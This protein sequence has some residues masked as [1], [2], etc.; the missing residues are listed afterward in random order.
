MTISFKFLSFKLA[1]YNI[2]LYNYISPHLESAAEVALYGV[3]LRWVGLHNC[4]GLHP[5]LFLKQ[6]MQVSGWGCSVGDG[7]TRMH[8]LYMQEEGNYIYIIL[9]SSLSLSLC[10]VSLLPPPSIHTLADLAP[11]PLRCLTR[12]WLSYSPT[13]ITPSWPPLGRTHGWNWGR[14][15]QHLHVLWS[16]GTLFGIIRVGLV[17]HCHHSCGFSAFVK[18]QSRLIYILRRVCIQVKLI[19]ANPTSIPSITGNSNKQLTKLLNTANQWILL[20]NSHHCN[21]A[22]V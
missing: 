1:L 2:I 8:I 17:R 11:S 5:P 14:R 3:P 16:V 9:F 6:V 18:N 20:I 19:Q 22:F 15:R 7:F 4:G 10:S 12:M 13:H 21:T